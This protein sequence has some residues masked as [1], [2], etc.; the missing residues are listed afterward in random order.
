MSDYCLGTLP[1]DVFRYF[2]AIECAN[3][4][5]CMTNSQRIQNRVIALSLFRTVQNVMA[6]FI[7]V[8]QLGELLVAELT[9][10]PESEV[11]RVF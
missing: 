3:Y 1:R 4:S 9:Q 11:H 8:I 7:T 5:T 2:G 10:H 6:R